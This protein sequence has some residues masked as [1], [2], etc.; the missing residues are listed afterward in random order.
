M[1]T[2]KTLKDTAGNIIYPQT[3]VEAVYDSTGRTWG[4]AIESKID[5]VTTPTAGNIPK[6]TSDGQLED[7][8][9]SIYQCGISYVNFYYEE[10]GNQY[11][12]GWTVGE[13]AEAFYAS[14][15]VVG[16]FTN[17]NTVFRLMR[18]YRYRYDTIY[19]AEFVFASL[20]E[21]GIELLSCHTDDSE[22]TEWTH[23]WY[24]YYKGGLPSTLSEDEG[25]VLQVDSDGNLEAAELTKEYTATT[26]TTWTDA[27]GYYTQSVTVTGLLATDNPIVDLVTTTSGFEAEQEAWGKVFKVITEANSITLY[28]SEAIT[29][30]LNLLIKVVR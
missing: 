30:A 27:T 20:T 29:T 11:T 24:P 22:C 2:I 6:L 9:R 25:K 8:G 19:E 14:E 17:D 12:S 4:E 26:T 21:G 7:S 23:T 16:Y 18:G 10:I 1:A 28:A 5:K 3:R 15:D 13:I